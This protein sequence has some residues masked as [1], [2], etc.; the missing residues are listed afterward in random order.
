MPE[1]SR[2]KTIE[3]RAKDLA[4]PL[5]AAQGLELLDVEYLREHDR[6]VLRLVVDK[7]GGAVGLDDCVA[8]SRSVESAIDA[9]D[10]VQ[11]E[12]H[13][14]VSSPGLDRPLKKPDHF[15]RVQGKKVKVK[16]FGP[17]GEPPRRNFSGLLKGV[18]EDAVTIEV[19][20]AGAFRI[21]FKE[22]AKAN[23]EFEFKH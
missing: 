11:Q 21:P 20:G 4:E 8:V 2:H 18:A 12:F 6:W 5:I 13:L 10:L 14:E 22:I 9:E 19:E 3:A 15:R 16:T 1:Q 7:A 17:L 23:L